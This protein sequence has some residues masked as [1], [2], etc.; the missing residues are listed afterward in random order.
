MLP[1]FESTS[2][3]EDYGERAIFRLRVPEARA[4]ALR[5]ALLDG[6]SGRAEVALGDP[7]AP[8]EPG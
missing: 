4:D 2:L 3:H 1:R 8:E 7:S 6:T 5:A